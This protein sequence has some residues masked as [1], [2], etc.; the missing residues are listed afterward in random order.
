[1]QIFPLKHETVAH[2]GDGPIAAFKMPLLVTAQTAQ[3]NEHRIKTNLVSVSINAECTVSEQ[4][5]DRTT[6]AA[7][8]WKAGQ[9]DRKGA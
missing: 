7:S 4:I 1:M 3:E 2:R 5:V 6:G 9:I 8:G